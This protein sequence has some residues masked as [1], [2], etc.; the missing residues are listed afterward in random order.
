MSQVRQNSAF[1]APLGL[2]RA[3][4]RQHGGS[5]RH[6]ITGATEAPGKDRESHRAKPEPGPESQGTAEKEPK[7]PRR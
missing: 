3:G 2:E 6:Q 4:A 1:A 5:Q 7:A